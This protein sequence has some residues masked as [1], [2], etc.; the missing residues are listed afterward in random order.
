MSRPRE[1][2]ADL[3]LRRCMEVF[4][5][6]GFHATS[7]EDLTR[8]TQVKKQSLYGVFKNKRELF[9]KSLALYREENLSVLEKRMACETS[10]V[11]RLEA[12]CE[13]ALYA[14]DEARIRGCLIINTSLEFGNGDADINREIGQMMER[15]EGMI[16]QAIRD[17]QAEGAITSRL[18]SRELALHLSNAINGA[19]MMEKSGIS[20]EE[21]LGVLRTSIALIEA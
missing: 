3:A 10:P 12:I 13:A 2:D 21:I 7:Y 16:E 8:T 4:W 19:K 20:R 9:L 17:G 14:D 1:F 5:T 15:T 6:K 18:G 11:R